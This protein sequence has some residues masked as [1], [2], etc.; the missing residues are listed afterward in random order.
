M[1]SLITELFQDH[2]N[3]FSFLNNSNDYPIDIKLK[4]LAEKK[5]ELEFFINNILTID[6]TDNTGKETLFLDMYYDLKIDEI[7]IKDIILNLIKK[8]KEKDSLV[9]FKLKLLYNSYIYQLIDNEINL[10]NN[11]YLNVHCINDIYFYKKK[12]NELIEIKKKYKFCRFEPC[13]FLIFNF[14]SIKNNFKSNIEELSFYKEIK[15]YYIK[16]ISDFIINKE[17]EL[18]S[19]DIIDSEL[20]INY[21]ENLKKYI[22]NEIDRIDTEINS[23][24]NSI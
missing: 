16:M 21:N 4:T 5:I 9:D 8:E 15:I 1:T 7:H 11:K 10:I 12:K 14:R 18:Q 6:N 24:I 20:A 17:K 3:K 19:N 13:D 23:L 22:K 2:I